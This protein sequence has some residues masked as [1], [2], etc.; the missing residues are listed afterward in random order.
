VTRGA[1]SRDIGGENIAAADE[2]SGAQ[3]HGAQDLLIGEIAS[4]K[5]F[6]ACHYR[7]FL[8]FVCRLSVAAILSAKSRV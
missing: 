4:Q 8:S 2:Q 1:E 5:T 6:N 7:F 3:G